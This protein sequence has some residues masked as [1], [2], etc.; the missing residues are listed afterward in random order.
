M[1]DLIEIV[2]QNVR[3]SL[4][5]TIL[6]CILFAAGVVSLFYSPID[7]DVY[8]KV[9]IIVL[10]LVVAALKDPKPKG[11]GRDKLPLIIL[12]A[13][14]VSSCATE[15]RCSEKYGTSSSSDSTRIEVKEV[16]RDTIIYIPG[17]SVVHYIE[18][19]CDS[20]GNL[21]P[22]LFRHKGSS[23]ASSTVS[24]T[25]K[26][27]TVECECEKENRI[28]KKLEREISHL[29]TEKTETK[30]VYHEKLPWWKKIGNGLKTFLI[31]IVV[32]IVAYIIGSFRLHN[33]ILKR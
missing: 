32:F 4:F 29:R 2:I 17:D 28:I 25:P 31:S 14:A 22:A 15:R 13:L 24:I 23:K 18:N 3:G 30:V 12:L 33:L 1:K 11:K 20:V 6:G 8:Y 16:T 5:T 19:P 10:G 27:I 26:G 21:K 7:I 9:G